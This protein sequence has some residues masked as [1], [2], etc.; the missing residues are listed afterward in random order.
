M[1]NQVVKHKFAYIF[2]LIG[3]SLFLIIFLGAWPNKVMQRFAVLGVMAFYT[4][5]GVITHI[6]TETITKRVAL[7]YVTAALFG[8]T[9][10]LVI[11]L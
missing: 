5:W 11:T 2:L 1:K 4:L 9:L 7:E 3:L 6:H 8:G 10:L